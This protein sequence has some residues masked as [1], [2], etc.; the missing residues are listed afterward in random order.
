MAMMGFEPDKA[1]DIM[2]LINAKQ[3]QIIADK[4]L[5]FFPKASPQ[6]KK[7]IKAID[8][9]QQ[10]KVNEAAVAVEEIILNPKVTIQQREAFDAIIEDARLFGES[11]L[12]S[13]RGG[14]IP[15]YILQVPALSK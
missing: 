9:V 8:C 13:L 5:E 14:E 1:I 6:S 2:M 3:L 11:T 7:L 15:E 4:L 12:E 10:L